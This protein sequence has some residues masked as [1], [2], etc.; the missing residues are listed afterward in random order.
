[1]NG[2]GRFSPI[3]SLNRNLCSLLPDPIQEGANVRFGRFGDMHD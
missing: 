3:S 1:M 2:S